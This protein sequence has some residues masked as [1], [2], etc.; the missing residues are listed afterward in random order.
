MI[1]ASIFFV[2]FIIEIILVLRSIY[3]YEE[4]I[5]MGISKTGVQTIRFIRV[6][7]CLSVAKIVFLYFLSASIRLI[8][9]NPR[10]IFFNSSFGLHT[11]I[12]VHFPSQVS[13]IGH[14]L[15]HDRTYS[16]LQARRRDSY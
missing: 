12:S 14:L 3:R 1:K 7:L 13:V 16:N 11:I 4:W 2:S 8:R 5:I 15:S 10:T 6:H 9:E